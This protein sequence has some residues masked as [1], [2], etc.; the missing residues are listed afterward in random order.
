MFH[1]LEASI[2]IEYLESLLEQRED[3]KALD[4]AEQLLRSRENTSE[5]LLRIYSVLLLARHNVGEYRAAVEA[6]EMARRLAKDIDKWDSYGEACI[7]ISATYGKLN[8]QQEAL[9]A[10]YDYL[11]SLHLYSHAVKYEL[12]A[13]QNI[14]RARIEA[15]RYEEAKNVFL[16]LSDAAVRAQSAHQVAKAQLSL[17]EC[18]LQLGTLEDIPKFIST[19]ARY[20]RA[21]SAAPGSLDG[22]LMLARYRAMY[23]LKTGRLFRALL[24]ALR[25]E[26]IAQGEPR[27]HYEYQKIM[28][29]IAIERG[30]VTETV[31][32]GLAAHSYASLSNRPDLVLEASEFL[33]GITK[34]DPEALLQVEDYYS[35]P[36]SV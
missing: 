32:H 10:L 33:Y 15:G 8:L 2:V 21:N 1:L 20:L 25:G 28:A 6:G 18:S 24:L 4:Y 3:R 34:G 7:N 31:G 16:R 36:S 5:D 11:G 14:G 9:G 22:R 17:V 23:A 30:N 12:L 26:A 27:H 35:V 29:M 13:L 19:C